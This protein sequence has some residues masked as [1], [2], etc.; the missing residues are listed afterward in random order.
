MKE[1]INFEFEGFEPN[2]QLK[3]SC[4]EIYELVE[5]RAPSESSKQVCIK[6]TLF[7][8]Y[9]GNLKITSASC[10]FE[11]SSEKKEPEQ[12]M[13]DLY[14]KFTFEILNWNKKRNFHP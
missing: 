7:G 4:A 1:I 14:K 12:L 13:K 11:V 5:N 8:N 2:A 9:K 10:I 3:Q 6:K